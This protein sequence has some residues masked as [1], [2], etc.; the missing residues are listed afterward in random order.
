MAAAAPLV[1]NALQFDHRFSSPDEDFYQLP[2]GGQGDLP[3]LSAQ[4]YGMGPA[5]G[6]GTAAM[7]ASH[8]SSNPK[9]TQP[10]TKRPRPASSD[11]DERVAEHG[12]ADDDG[13]K[14]RS[15]GRP[16]LDT[17]DETAADVSLPDNCLTKS[18]SIT[19]S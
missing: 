6:G 16:R 10:D 4:E 11:D 5:Y 12:G 8:S 15:R 14:K 2:M 7:T 19:R 17:K 3:N 1:P 13:R 18:N 9:S